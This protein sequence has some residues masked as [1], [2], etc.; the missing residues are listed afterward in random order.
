MAALKI[1]DV[2]WVF[3]K[4]NEAMRRRASFRK[5]IYDIMEF[6]EGEAYGVLYNAG[7]LEITNAFCAAEKEYARKETEDG[8]DAL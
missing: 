4:L 3:T 8:R 2:A 5:L 1:D 6:P 7:G